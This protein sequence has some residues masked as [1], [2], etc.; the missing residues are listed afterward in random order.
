MASG[1]NDNQDDGSSGFFPD[2]L[3]SY[4]AERDLYAILHVDRDVRCQNSRRFSIERLF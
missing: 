3:E 2:D 4:D 1:D